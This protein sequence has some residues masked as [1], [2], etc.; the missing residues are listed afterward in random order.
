MVEVRSSENAFLHLVS[1]KESQGTSC[2]LTDSGLGPEEMEELCRIL[3]Q[4]NQLAELD[5]SRNRLGNEGL[6]HLL[7]RLPKMCISYLMK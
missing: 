2:R 4:C 5:F 1:S 7:E 3:E 6:R